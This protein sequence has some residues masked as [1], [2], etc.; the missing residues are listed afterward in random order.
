M[1]NPI[2]AALAYARQLDAAMPHAEGIEHAC[3][4]DVGEL[5]GGLS[6]A[7]FAADLERWLADDDC[8]ALIGWS[9]SRRPEDKAAWW[10]EWAKS[11]LHQA[12]LQAAA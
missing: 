12:K 7:G 3:L 8:G 9:L 11:L 5:C 2:A 10:L 6:N 1:N 4:M